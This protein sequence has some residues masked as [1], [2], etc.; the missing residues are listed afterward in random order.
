MACIGFALLLLLLL[1]RDDLHANAK[2]TLFYCADPIGI[3][4]KWY[5]FN[6]K[7]DGYFVNMLH[8]HGPRIYLL[9]FV[10]CLVPIATIVI[11]CAASVCTRGYT[12]KHSTYNV[13]PSGAALM[14]INELHRSHIQ[15]CPGQATATRIKYD[16]EKENTLQY[17]L[18][19]RR[20][21]NR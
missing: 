13:R 2:T 8:I 20:I 4:F 9:L 5:Q 16:A 21:D 10:Y 3:P 1:H 17:T 15:G 11:L 14:G 6:D 18:H 12:R 7:T 19:T